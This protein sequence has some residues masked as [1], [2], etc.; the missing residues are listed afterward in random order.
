MSKAA[1]ADW[2]YK[3][4]LLILHLVA[5]TSFVLNIPFALF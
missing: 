1:E 2:L 4:S 3:A 5:W